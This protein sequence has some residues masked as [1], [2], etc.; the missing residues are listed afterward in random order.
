MKE[1]SKN[2]KQNKTKNS[3]TKI[4]LNT[5]QDFNKLSFSVLK[6]T[7]ISDFEGDY[8]NFIYG[9]A[10]EKEKNPLGKESLKTTSNNLINNK[11]NS[12]ELKKSPHKSPKKS[13]RKSPHKSPEKSPQKSP[14]KSPK[15]SPKKSPHK[16]PKKSPKKSPHKSPKRSP[17]KAS[18]NNISNTTKKKIEKKS[19]TNNTAKHHL[20]NCKQE[21]YNK[22]NSKDNFD[23]TIKRRKQSL[24]LPKV[25]HNEDIHSLEKELNI[26]YIIFQ[27]KINTRPGEDLGVIG[28]INE[29]GM[30]DKNK[31]LKLVMNEENIWT[32]KI[33]YNLTE[34][35][36][37]EFKF[38]FISNG[39]IKQWEDG[40]NRKIIYE[41]LKEA[42]KPNTKKEYLFEGKNINGNNIIYNSQNY[43]LTIICDWNKK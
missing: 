41:Q 9:Q 17:K 10:L 8:F 22:N 7:K 4:T 1:N 3:Q 33:N 39:N 35:N 20:N 36:M 23:T 11:N 6:N 18:N 15:K 31:A 25:K 40:D 29:L 16:S 13:P 5:K 32:I 30:W 24:P 28:S 2:K 14:Q 34:N 27:M 19:E 21:D 12:K 42:I 43:T 38:I 26:K 37:F